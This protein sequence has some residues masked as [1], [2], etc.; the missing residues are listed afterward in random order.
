MQYRTDT[1]TLLLAHLPYGRDAFPRTIG[2]LA[3]QLRDLARQFFVAIR[4]F[5]AWLVFF[6]F[7]IDYLRYS[8]TEIISIQFIIIQTVMNTFGILCICTAPCF[9]GKI[10]PRR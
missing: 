1:D 10:K 2:T 6:G 8:F 9:G 4:I 3:D 7:H 5:V